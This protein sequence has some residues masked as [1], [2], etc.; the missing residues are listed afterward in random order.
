MTSYPF[1]ATPEQLG[2]FPEGTSLTQNNITLNFGETQNL[3]VSASLLNGELPAGIS[4]QQQ[5][6]LIQLSGLLRDVS[7]DITHVFTFRITNGTYHVDR[8]FYLQVQNTQLRSFEWI[9]DNQLPLLNVYGVLPVSTQVRATTQPLAVITYEILNLNVLTQGVS[10]DANTGMITWDL[11]WQ[12]ET[13]Y[14]QN[15]D[16]VITHSGLYAC[17]LS[18]T[19]GSISAPSGST[20]VDTDYPAWQAQR[21]YP[22]NQVVHHDQGK[23]YLCVS[24]GVSFITGP[25]GTGTSISDGTTIWR[26]IEQAPVWQIVPSNTII[27]QNV[28]VSAL[29]GSEQIQRTFVINLVGVPSDPLWITPAGDLPDA[30]TEF[31]YSYQLQAVD[32]DLLAITWS[33]VNLPSWL[34][35]SSTGLL[36][37]FAPSVQTDV[38]YTFV[39]TIQDGVSSSTRSFNLT[40]VESRVEFEWITAPDLGSVPDGVSFNQDLEARSS[41]PGAFVRYGVS[42]GML[43]V[44]V[45]L[46]P[47]NGSL[48]GFVEYHAQDKMYQFEILASDGVESLVRSFM[49]RI[50]AKQL[51]HHW[52]LQI[53]V[54]GEQK[55]QLE[56]LNGES[57]VPT[58]DLYLPD[59]SGYGRVELPEITLISGI[60][61]IN[62][63]ELRTIIQPYLHNFVLQLQDLILLPGRLSE[64]QLLSVRA[65]DADSVQLWQ[66]Q[67]LYVKGTRVTNPEGVRY[68]SQITGTSGDSP[69]RGF[70]VN[71][72]DGDQRWNWDSVPNASTSSGSPLPWYPYHVYE[73]GQSVMNSGHLY[74]VIQAGTSAGDP[75]PQGTS[76]FISDGS[77]VWRHS[78]QTA[79]FNYGNLFYPD[80]VFNIRRIIKDQ[81]GWSTQVGSGALADVLVSF[82]GMVTQVNITEP[83][84]GYFR[85]PR[86]NFV[87]TGSGAQVSTTLQIVGI[88]VVNGGVNWQSGELIELD[89]G[90]GTPAQLQVTGTTVIGTVQSVQILHAGEFTQIPSAV[91]YVQKT[92]RTC[93]VR[94][95]GGLRA[96]TVTAPGEGYTRDATQINFLGKEYGVDAQQFIDEFDLMLTLA[97]VNTSWAQTQDLSLKFNPFQGQ[98][99][100]VRFITA[101]IQG[102]EWQGYARFDSDTTSWD[103]DHTRFVDQ[104]PATH[105]TWDQDQTVWD[106]QS[107][108][109]DQPQVVWPN[110]SETIFDNNQTIWDYYRTIF[111]QKPP[112]TGSQFSRTWVWWFGKPHDGAK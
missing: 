14:V 94:L 78:F 81:V 42:G 35:L 44:G 21:F 55:Q 73:L 3:P 10:Q 75:G 104:T 34:N 68:I 12:P 6:Y 76:Q 77:V 33:S 54:W 79:P 29:S 58:Q 1:W 66:P 50:Q 83:G 60:T 24:E 71:I 108:V 22:V 20:F 100:D 69:P 51:A 99:L 95:D 9:T 18:G 11:S 26:Y 65:Q 17:V 52:S 19:S 102:V 25:S 61:G 93:Q 111:D 82:S 87:G 64:Y 97:H 89:L 107:T 37:G 56:I 110:W 5:G 74:E 57:L 30:Q 39:V 38:T 7:E 59:V 47:Q 63:Q 4:W 112:T 85:S 28:L 2:S 23:I 16:L 32:P 15:K 48:N 98:V 45:S 103:G 40:V 105:T 62:A 88:T 67:T 96:C 53:P 43:P 8:T 49:I 72:L 84:T 91:I 92:G 13:A 90:N 86:V 41:R 31:T 27:P 36:F 109:W 101:T 46:D 80:N 106:N 70:G